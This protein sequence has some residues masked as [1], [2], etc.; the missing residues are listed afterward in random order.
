MLNA[1]AADSRVEPEVDVE[2]AAEVEESESESVELLDL[3]AVA[4][5]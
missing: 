5:G 1:L 3:V 4:V 2:D